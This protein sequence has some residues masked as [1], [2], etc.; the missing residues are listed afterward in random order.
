[1]HYELDPAC[2]LANEDA[3]LKRK[4]KFEAKIYEF[5]VNFEIK[6]E[7]VLNHN[8]KSAWRQHATIFFEFV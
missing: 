1:M 3:G 8:L 5:Y 4:T 2:L 7:Q 6:R